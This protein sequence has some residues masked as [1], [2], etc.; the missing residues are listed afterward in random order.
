MSAKSTSQAARRRECRHAEDELKAIPY[1]LAPDPLTTA[2]AMVQNTSMEVKDA[3]GVR[4]ITNLEAVKTAR[5]ML[6]GR[7]F[8]FVLTVQNALSSTAA[9][10]FL[11]TIPISPAVISYNEWPAISALFDEVRQ[12]GNHVFLRP[13]VGATGSLLT[14]AAG[15][16]VINQDIWA[17]FDCININTAPAG[18]QA[19]VR[20][21]GSKPIARTT[22]DRS[23]AVHLVY[24]TPPDLPYASTAT[25]A[26]QSPPSGMV[27]SWSFANSVALTA[28]TQ[29]YQ[30]TLKTLVSLRCRI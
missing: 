9:G 12:L 14:A 16:S 5:T 10:A 19:V 15:A 28:S 21:E 23:G 17:G 24:A 22:D 29:Y 18:M 2:I 30:F 1:H 11:V 7:T 4:S 3:T 20:L 13:N 25:P 8:K 6:R 26:V 27:G